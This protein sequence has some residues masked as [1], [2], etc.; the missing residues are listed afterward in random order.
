MEKPINWDRYFIKMCYLI[1]EKSKDPST[2]VGAVIVYPDNGICS[3]GFNGFPR[4]VID[5]RDRGL[6][7]DEIKLRYERPLKYRFIEHAE[8]NAIYNAARHGHSTE[9]CRLY[10]P[11]LPCAECAKGIVQA[12]ITEVVIDPEFEVDPELAKRW[13]DE[14]KVTKKMFEEAGITLRLAKF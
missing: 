10:V 9:H 3:T 13:E 1:S 7:E 2:K 6:S 12:G 11:F 14:H 8:R 5:D 4:G